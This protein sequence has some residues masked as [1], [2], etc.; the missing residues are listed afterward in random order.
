MSM[1][2][3]AARVADTALRIAELRE[4]DGIDR[5]FQGE[6]N[7]SP[8][9]LARFTNICRAIFMSAEDSFLQHEQGLLDRT[10][11]ESFEASVELAQAAEQLGCPPGTV[12][13]RLA[14]ARSVMGQGGRQFD[15]YL[16][17]RA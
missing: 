3:R 17:R 10:A 14:R 12:F 11:F 7:V 8:K 1:T 15:L 4:S 13:S 6:R 2:T 5:C 16:S 9:D